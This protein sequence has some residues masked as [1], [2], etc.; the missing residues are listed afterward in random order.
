M[1]TQPAMTPATQYGSRA[2]D[3]IGSIFLG[4]G[5]VATATHD[6]INAIALAVAGAVILIVNL[7]RKLLPELTS[8]YRQVAEARREQRKLDLEVELNNLKEK[9]ALKHDELE[10]QMVE[11]KADAQ[12][13]AREK[14]AKLAAQAAEL[15]ELRQK[16]ED[17]ACVFVGD[18]GKSRCSGRTTPLPPQP[19][20]PWAQ[21][22]DGGNATPATPA[23][24][25]VS[26]STSTR[27]A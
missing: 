4:G 12:A 24:P 15:A 21:S 5:T 13:D 6:N 14:E 26:A 23:T 20:E 8:L 2:A 17:T 1:E 7:L 18:D 10:G 27:S 22:A 25:V 16:V 3:W 11:L 19:G 9:A